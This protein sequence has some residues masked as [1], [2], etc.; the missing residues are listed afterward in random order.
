MRALL[1]RREL[2]RGGESFEH[3]EDGVSLIPAGIR[4]LIQEF[5]DFLNGF[6][7]LKYR[8]TVIIRD[9]SGDGFAVAVQDGFFAF[10]K[11]GEL[12]DHF[13]K[14]VLRDEVHPLQLELERFRPFTWDCER[15]EDP[16]VG[17]VIGHF[18]GLQGGT[19][20]QNGCI[21]IGCLIGAFS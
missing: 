5:D 12:F 7:V 3:G 10:G 11:V 16:L 17:V 20:L 19:F 1:Q 15:D 9:G 18:D 2:T 8:F 6:A 13:L 4:H 14:V 21:L